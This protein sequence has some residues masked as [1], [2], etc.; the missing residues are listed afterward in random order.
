MRTFNHEFITSFLGEKIT[1]LH[2]TDKELEEIDLK[3]S[4]DIASAEER[5][6]IE[7]EDYERKK[8]KLR[9][10]QKYLMENKLQ[11]LKAGVYTPEQLH[12]EEKIIAK[13]LDSL[14]LKEMASEEAMR[15][16]MKDVMKF[17][18]R[19]KTLAGLYESAN[20]AQKEKIIQNMFSELFIS[21]STFRFRL[22]DDYLCFE[23]RLQAVCD[24]NHLAFR[25]I[26]TK[27]QNQKK[28]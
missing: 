16:T 5:R 13:K 6:L 3:L 10:D 17:S 21:D 1:H 26:K 4:K 18:E 2:F 24:P 25:T 15:E 8:K 14:M 28:N 7:I 19:V 23:N 9:A 22:Q 11:F 20:P 12:Y 27:R